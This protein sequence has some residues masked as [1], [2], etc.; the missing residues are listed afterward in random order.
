MIVSATAKGKQY[1]EDS[2]IFDIKFKNVKVT[3]VHFFLYEMYEE[4]N[5]RI[6]K[7]PILGHFIWKNVPVVFKKCGVFATENNLNGKKI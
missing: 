4:V 6:N 5:I 1:V 7:T 3:W 2:I